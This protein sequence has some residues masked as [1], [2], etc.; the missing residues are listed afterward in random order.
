MHTRKS[1]LDGRI[2]FLRTG[3]GLLAVLGLAACADGEGLA[4]LDN[5]KVG[6]ASSS[7]TGTAFVTAA[8]GIAPDGDE[9]AANP[10][11]PDWPRVIVHKSPTCGCCAL[12][13]EHLVDA[14]FEVETR[15]HAP[16]ALNALK[17]E[18]GIPPGKGACH[19]AQVGGYFVEGHVP[20]GDIKRM[21]SDRID[22]RGL[23][24]PGM[25]MGSPGMEMPDG[26]TTPYAVE[27]VHAD[28]S[29]TVH[30]RH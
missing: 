20:A 26:R 8:G 15:D 3:L 18:L 22:A 27:S 6:A 16:E 28:G 25:P 14:G 21:L 2:A 29:T 7:A 4:G 24:L 5:A 30:M 9:V 10:G 12:W 11:D 1:N 23:V 13:V 19:T 17:H